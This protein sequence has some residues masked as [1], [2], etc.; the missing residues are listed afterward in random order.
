MLTCF[1][2]PVTSLQ[3]YQVVVPP[4]REAVI[5]PE[6][7][8]S[9]TTQFAKLLGGV[10]AEVVEKTLESLHNIT[11]V[12]ASVHAEAAL[13]SLVSVDHH[14][15]VNGTPTPIATLLPVRAL[16][17]VN[18]LTRTHPLHVLTPG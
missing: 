1:N 6:Y 5:T 3:A 18:L 9:F 2:A 11:N 4:N 10:D 15:Q 7:F 16:R 14:V 12:D 13:M 17:P 8:N